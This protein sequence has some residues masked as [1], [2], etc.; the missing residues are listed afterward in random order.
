MK[1]RCDWCGEDPL[2][3]SYHDSQWGVPVH[4]DR[5][6]FEMLSLEGAQA[7]LSWITIL[8]K[9]DNYVRL[10]DN[11][12]FRKIV[13]YDDHDIQR[14]LAD[15]GI[16]RNKLKVA[17][18]IKNARGTLAIIEEF[19]SLDNYL[20]R[21]VDGV[22]LQNCW[23]TNA[24]IPAE[25]KLSTQLSK[26]LKKRGFSFVGPTICYALMQSIGM[27]NDHLVDCFRYQEVQ[28]LQHI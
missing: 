17:S 18:V 16:V 23:K 27:V 24:E 3:V 22:P 13:H 26:D 9:R 1:K 2:Y 12:D 25:T 28:E 6:L 5:T 21:Y 7:G 15:S 19:G 11:F 10:F 8:R 14:L 20:W 4:D